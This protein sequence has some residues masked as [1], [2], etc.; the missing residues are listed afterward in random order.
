MSKIEYKKD[1]EGIIKE[2]L[3]WELYELM[4]LSSHFDACTN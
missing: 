3:C 1:A 4:F 2:N